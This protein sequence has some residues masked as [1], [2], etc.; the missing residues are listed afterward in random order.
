MR[1]L[2]NVVESMVVLDLDGVLDLDDLPPELGGTESLDDKPGRPVPAEGGA[3]TAELI[4]K[5]WDEIERWAIENTL[6]LTSGNREE[7]ARVLDIGV[8]TIYRKL[9]K[10]A[11]E[12]NGESGGL[13]G[14]EGSLDARSPEDR[15]ESA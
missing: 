7:A 12:E 11:R 13:V 9:E 1:E 4:G 2:Q 3:A 8:R 14:D 6:K 15:A 10:Y 5:T